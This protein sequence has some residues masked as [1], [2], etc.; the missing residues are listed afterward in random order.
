MVPE[1]PDHHG[2]G[3]GRV[4]DGKNGLYGS[5]VTKSGTIIGLFFLY[6]I[7]SATKKEP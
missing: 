2:G 5:H 7:Y 6:V 3:P 1:A 4:E